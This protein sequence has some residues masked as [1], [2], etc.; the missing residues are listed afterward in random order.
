MFID[1]CRLVLMEVPPFSWL[2][3]DFRYDRIH[4][5]AIVKAAEEKLPKDTSLDF[6]RKMFGLTDLGGAFRTACVAK[7]TNNNVP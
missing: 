7:P 1:L 4:E 6:I 3:E 2:I 5:L